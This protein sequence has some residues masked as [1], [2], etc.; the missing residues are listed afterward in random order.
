MS[1]KGIL[2]PIRNV[3]HPSASPQQIRE[4]LSRISREPRWEQ[5]DCWAFF[6]VG[7]SPDF[8]FPSLTNAP[9]VSQRE[10][11]ENFY[12]ELPG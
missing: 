4:E 10:M 1:G 5:N 7:G 8:S 2:I 9:Q 11:F 3:I 6:Q 12:A